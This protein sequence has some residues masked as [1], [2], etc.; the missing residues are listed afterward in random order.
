MGRR[1]LVVAVGTV[2]LVAA[3]GWWL[4]LDRLSAEE[5]RLVGTWQQSDPRTGEWWVRMVLA[6]D[7]RVWLCSPDEPDVLHLA[8]PGWAVRGGSFSGNDEPNPVRRVLRPLARR[9]GLAA[10]PD[11][12][13]PVTVTDN[14]LIFVLADGTREVWTRAPAD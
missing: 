11:R 3:G 7:R 1:Q 13:W 6:P 5:R 9:L 10:Y 2:A 4:S 12:A 8:Q 14:E